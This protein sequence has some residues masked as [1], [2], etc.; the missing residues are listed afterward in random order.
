MALRNRLVALLFGFAFHMTLVAMS[1]VGFLG[2]STALDNLVQRFANV[3]AWLVIIGGIAF[4]LVYSQVQRK[5]ERRNARGLALRDWAIAFL[6]GIGISLVLVAMGM[7]GGYFGPA[8][9]W[10][11]LSRQ[12]SAAIVLGLAG[13]G[14]V[15]ALIDCALLWRARVAMVRKTAP[16]IGARLVLAAVLLLFVAANF[17]GSPASGAVFALSI[18]LVVALGIVL[19]MLYI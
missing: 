5:P 14:A 9:R 2:P 19:D 12:I 16:R 11:R 6:I 4:V 1:F 10:Q 18:F 8:T 3:V 13:I 7:A 17:V 15:F